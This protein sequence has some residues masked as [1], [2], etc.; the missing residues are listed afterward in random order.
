[1]Q[2]FQLRDATR[3]D[4]G[5]TYEITRDA[6]RAYVEQTWGRWDERG[7]RQKH[8]HNYT[9]ETHRLIEVGNAVAGLVAVEQLPDHVWLA[10]L[11]LLLAFR[12]LGIGAAVIA[13]VLQEADRRGVPVRLRVLRV[14]TRAQALYARHGFRV[15][16]E[17]P[18][19][20]FMERPV[21]MAD[22]RS[23]KS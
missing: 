23:E 1:M 21:R 9:P 12:G 17:T 11:Y 4:L 5:R 14:N 19:R 15:V 18:E 2:P 13:H 16:Y 6:M 20:I 3:D 8:Q 10:K 7:H 22:V